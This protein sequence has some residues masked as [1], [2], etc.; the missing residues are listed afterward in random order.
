M[1]MLAGTGRFLLQHV[2]GK[3]SGRGRMLGIARMGMNWDIDDLIRHLQ[4]SKLAYAEPVAERI[5]RQNS[6]YT[7]KDFFELLGFSEV[8][9]GGQL[10][11][12]DLAGID[13]AGEGGVEGGDEHVSG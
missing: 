7:S 4:A 13:G 5:R 2:I 6:R 11:E 12:G 1:A 9:V 8:G 3:L 10:F